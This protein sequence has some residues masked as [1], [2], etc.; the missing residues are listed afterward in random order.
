MWRLVS[1]LGAD[2]LPFWVWCAEAHRARAA[3]CQALA[4]ALVASYPESPLSCAPA[5]FPRPGG[6]GRFRGLGCQQ[7]RGMPEDDCC[8][9]DHTLWVC[10][11]HC[12]LRISSVCFLLSNPDPPPSAPPSMPTPSTLKRPLLLS[13]RTGLGLGSPLGP[14]KNYSHAKQLPVA[15]RPSVFQSPDDDDE[16]DYEQWLEIKG[17]L[18]DGH[19]SYPLS[20]QLWLEPGTQRCG[21]GQQPTGA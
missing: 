3:A 7:N 10:P 11:Q 2:C 21:L 17:K 9:D 8:H 14:V 1:H 20:W 18:W 6:R 19:G 13:K 12:P 16:E 15:H 5:H 4:Y